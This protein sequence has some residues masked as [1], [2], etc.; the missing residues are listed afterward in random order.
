MKKNLFEC[1]SNEEVRSLFL[2]ENELPKKVTKV[3][4]ARDLSSKEIKAIKNEFGSAGLDIN[5]LANEIENAVTTIDEEDKA[6]GYQ[7]ILNL[8]LEEIKNKI[9]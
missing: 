9:I 2:K 1:T 3:K 6:W 4:E 5:K 7:S 8:V